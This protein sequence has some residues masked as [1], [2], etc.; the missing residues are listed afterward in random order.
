MTD[1]EEFRQ[2]LGAYAVG[3]LDPTERTE[4][5]LHLSDCPTCRREL[6]LLAPLPGL[7]RRL[8]PPEVEPKGPS[9][10]YLAA[11]VKK[12][13]TAKRRRFASAGAALIGVAA[14]VLIGV[15]VVT[16][17]GPVGR[18]I[19][20]RSAAGQTTGEA[21]L[22][23]R[24]WGTQIELRLNGLPP[25]AGFV[26]WVQGQGGSRPAGSWG[27]PPNGRVLVELASA[28]QPDRITGLRV[29]TVSGISV[30]GGSGL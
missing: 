29:S 3:A 5:D 2:R 28:L 1:H 12:R 22:Y 27:R 26:A 6:S 10:A 25:A 14:S 11:E 17:G 16:N 15:A 23:S 21:V 18:S 4:T 20:L 13:R 24:P 30:L 7:L 19:P 9:L 8:P